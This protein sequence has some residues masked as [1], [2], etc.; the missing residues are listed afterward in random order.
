MISARAPEEH[1]G[2]VINPFP[3]RGPAIARPTSLWLSAVVGYRLSAVGS[4]LSGMALASMVFGSPVCSWLS[5]IAVQARCSALPQVKAGL[6][7]GSSRFLRR[8]TRR[9]S[10]VGKAST[11]CNGVH[12]AGNWARR[13]SYLGEGGH[14]LASAA[15]DLLDKR[16]MRA[17]RMKRDLLKVRVT[18]TPWT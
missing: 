8:S 1:G 15:S 6:R 18:G 13:T 14:L 5:G 2:L 12:L 3:H 16:G 11:I 7:E 10:H 9:Y 17:M 4:W